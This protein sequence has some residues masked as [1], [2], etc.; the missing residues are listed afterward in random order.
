MIILKVIIIVVTV[1]NSVET[2]FAKNLVHLKRV[3]EIVTGLNCLLK[4]LLLPE[5]F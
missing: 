5:L 1:V 2:N 4:F 3:F